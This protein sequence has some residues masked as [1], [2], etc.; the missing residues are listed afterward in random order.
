MVS[1]STSKK[2]SSLF[3]KKKKR[4]VRVTHSYLK[5]CPSLTV[6]NNNNKIS[7]CLSTSR[8]E[9]K[10]RMISVIFFIHGVRL[11]ANI[12]LGMSSNYLSYH[13]NCSCVN[14][15]QWHHKSTHT[16]VNKICIHINIIFFVHIEISHTNTYIKQICTS[17]RLWEM[18]T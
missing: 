10:W 5:R 15:D 8:K 1:S 11:K 18:A 7:L 17:R 14:R 6:N 16:H 3:T 13:F 12:A 2:S 9:E 4:K